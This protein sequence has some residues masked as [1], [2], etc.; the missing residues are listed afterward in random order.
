MSPL[1]PSRKSEERRRNLRVTPDPLLIIRLTSGNHGIVL[2]LSHGGVGFLAGAPVEEGQEIGFTLTN[3]SEPVAEGTGQLMWKDDTGKRAGLRFT[4]LPDELRAMLHSY[5]RREDTGRGMRTGARAR[6]TATF[7]LGEPVLPLGEAGFE[8]R[9]QVSIPA[10]LGEAS[11]A[12]LHSKRLR[13]SAN[14]LT[15]LLACVIVIAIWFS[16]DRR[17]AIVAASRFKQGLSR[18]LD[19]RRLPQVH[20]PAVLARLPTKTET[21]AAT[22]AGSPAAES[23]PAVTAPQAD[24]STDAKPAPEESPNPPEPNGPSA[25]PT[26]NHALPVPKSITAAKPDG[27]QPPPAPVVDPGRSELALAQELLKK[28]GDPE[29]GAKAAQLLWQAV[30]K[31]NLTAEI[32]LA[33]LYL[34]GEAVPKSC[35]Q[36]RILLSAARNRKSETAARELDDL[37]RSGCE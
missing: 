13:W 34:A 31:G 1:S 22:S 32:E 35:S 16:V 23:T 29:A 37:A 5:L 6:K 18:L 8:E 10:E 30:E 3:K 33:D 17:D 15:A 24:T 21:P 4:H 2:D 14:I 20:N 19:V 36:A 9:S 26:L 25:S 27:D 12:V 7:A 11:S 28:N